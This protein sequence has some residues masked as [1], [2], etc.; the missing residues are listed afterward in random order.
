MTIKDVAGRNYVVSGS[1]TFPIEQDRIQ[2]SRIRVEVQVFNEL[3]KTYEIDLQTILDH[4]L[5]EQYKDGVFG[6]VTYYHDVYGEVAF[7]DYYD[8]GTAK[9]ENGKL[10]LPIKNASGVKSGYDIGTLTIRVDSTNYKSF[11]LVIHIVARNKIV[12]M[13]DGTV[14]ASDITYGQTLNDS[15]FTVTGSMRAPGI[16]APSAVQEVKGTFAWKD[17][18]IKPDAG[19]YEA[20][21]IF[22]PD[23]PEY[24]AATGKVSVKVDP[25]P[26]KI[27]GITAADKV[28]DGLAAAAT[29]CS[30]AVFDGKLEGDDLTV[31]AIGAFRAADANRED[32]LVV[33]L[34]L[35]LGGEDKDNYVIDDTDSQRETRARI[36]PATLTVT[37]D[38]N[39]SKTF[40]LADPAL[41]YTV[42]GAVDHETPAFTG[43]PAR[44][45][46][47]NAGSYAIALGSLALKD[48][49]SFKANNYDLKLADAGVNFTINKAAAPV[50]EDVTV[51]HKYTVTTGTA[52][53]AVRMPSDAGQLTYIPGS[54]STTGSVTVD[55]S[56]DVNTG[57]VSYNLSGGK[58]G[59]TVTLSMTIRSA[60]YE[61]AAVDVVI[62]L[63]ERDDQAALYIT[64]DTAVVYGQ[65][66]QLSANGGSG[67]GALTYGVTN[68]TGEATINQSSGVLTPVKVGNVRVTATKAG[69]GNYNEITSVPFEVTIT[70][71]TP[72]GEPKYTKITAGG[73]TLNDAALTMDGSTLNPNAGTL[74]WV[75]DEGNV[76]PN[77]TV[78]AAN[79][80]Y[81]WRFT[82][83]NGNYT[84]LTGEVTL[85]RVSASGGGGGGTTRYTVSFETNGGSKMSKQTVA[86]NTALKEPAA[87][88]KEGFDFAGW[89]TDKELKVKYDFSAKVTKSITLY[90]AWTE[91]DQ[92]EN[93]IVLTIGEKAAQVFGQTKTN[94][95]APKIVND[96]T[97]LPA[98][99]VAENLGADVKW[100]GE[101]ELVT[102]QGNNLKTGEE[103]TILIC[104]GSDLAYV[105]GKEIK[106]DSAAF[107]ENDRTYTP[108]RFISE[109]LGAS[110]D[111][112]ETEQKVV[113]TK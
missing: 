55:W 95:V 33:D 108:I 101:K 67:T 22:T 99:F 48:E 45:A 4:I 43:T 23:A 81:K 79:K 73:K 59:D 111:W 102:I 82:P 2:E 35:A 5:L 94:D 74:E 54:A 75:D 87:P 109:E 83:D 60:N 104:I 40:G 96:R 92:S 13:L 89:Y 97:M 63:T 9:I 20:E 49:G 65:T 53:I 38:A 46:G 57:A 93:Q 106:L 107:V 91:K 37:P 15:E 25:K 110:V 28:Y 17:G 61:D 3:A 26:V 18:T 51:S 86:R 10:T 85:Y 113:I 112:I 64:G 11:D 42:S 44:E 41:T 76:L 62:T 1:T 39:Q 14:H 6:T 78:V 50:I 36:T 90:A 66:L 72:T 52:Q 12:P 77:D 24:A 68:G 70:P 100:D 71:A 21:W 84:A 98:R 80:T 27:S 19:S 88:T 7:A 16:D 32:T 34:S 30:K 31:T 47:E 69:D 56:A 8:I 105:N 29:D 103:V 58:A